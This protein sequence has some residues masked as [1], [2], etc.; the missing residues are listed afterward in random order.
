MKKLWKRVALLAVIAGVAGAGA[1]GAANARVDEATKAY[2]TEP[3]QAPEAEAIVILGARVYSETQV[4]PMLHDRLE[5]GLAL[6]RAGK[7]PKIIVSGDNGQEEYDEVNAM[8]RFLVDRGVP[9]EDIFMDH[10]GF[11]T[12]ESMYRARDVFGVKKA[13]VVT[14][15][16]HLKRAVYVGRALGV[17]AYGVGSDQREHSG[18]ERREAREILARAKDFLLVHTTRPEPTYLGETYAI[19]GD[20]R[21]THD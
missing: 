6:Y 19:T 8:K 5:Q 17:D 12:Y 1:L 16:Y 7:A 21:Q 2:R 11:S 13:I 10:A 3:E 18:A 14:Q 4:S 9:E 20:G 15:S